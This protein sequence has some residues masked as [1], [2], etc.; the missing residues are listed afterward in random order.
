MSAALI[1][2]TGD[3][4][5]RALDPGVAVYLWAGKGLRHAWA[6]SQERLLRLRPEIVL[7]HGP[8]SALTSEHFAP[9]VAQV[10]AALPGVR[11]WVGIG[12]DG[13]AA[14]WRAGKCSAEQVVAPLRAAYAAAH[15]V[16]A[17]AVAPDLE[18]AWKSSKKGASVPD[19]RTRAELEALARRV[20]V[21][22][23]EAAPD[24][25]HVLVSYD[26]PDLHKAFPLRAVA[27]GT[28]VSVFAGMMY[29]ADGT[30]ARGELLRRVAW[31]G[32]EQEKAEGMGLLPDDVTGTDVP[33]DVDRVPVV[34]LHQLA[35][36][37][38]VT[39]IAE[40]PLVLTW[41]MPLIRDGGRADETG[42]IAL[43]AALYLRREVGAGPG[44]IAR[45]QARAGLVA[46]GIVGP[47]TLGK[48]E[49][50]HKALA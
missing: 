48:L 33:G 14:Q 30:P 9:L 1:C 6:K 42:L 11:V 35:P 2:R 18:A 15:A 22:G 24:A 50:Q 4:R 21:E 7:L 34:Q 31:A 37:D 47:R 49:A 43:E 41:A 46:D 25:V 5:P 45:F 29:A 40:S 28:P 38:L 3:G 8:P 10:R 26:I 32:R 39:V 12:G 19:V 36:E 27:T 13:W 16:G 23:G 17:E 44:A 20:M